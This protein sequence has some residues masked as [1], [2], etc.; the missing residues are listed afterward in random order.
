MSDGVSVL[1]VDDHALVRDALGSWLRSE[2][3]IRVVGEVGSADEA[4]AMAVQHRPD[5]VLMDI[6]MPEMDGVDAARA[7][8]EGERRTGG[9]LPII[10]LTASVLDGDQARYRQAGID[11][12]QA[13]PVRAKGLMEQIAELTRPG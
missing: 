12:C 1:L 10:A 9:H 4:V 5:V 11:A 3:G 13:K 6:D 7:I 2:D 8:R